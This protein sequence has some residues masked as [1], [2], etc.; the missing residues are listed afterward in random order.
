MHVS[1]YTGMIQTQCACEI[2]GLIRQAPVITLSCIIY[3]LNL[4]SC[5]QLSLGQICQN[6]TVRSDD[7]LGLSRLLAY[8]IAGP[9]TRF[10]QCPEGELQRRKEVVHTVTLHEIDVINSRTQVCS[11]RL[12]P[13]C[14]RCMQ[15]SS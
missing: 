15:E 14:L 5:G 10:V 11:L 9:A 12:S 13:S 3:S 6:L 7:S 1:S 4:P 2:S 8:T